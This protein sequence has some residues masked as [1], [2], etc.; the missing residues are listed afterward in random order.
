MNLAKE[1]VSWFGSMFDAEL[2]DKVLDELGAIMYGR[3]TFSIEPGKQV[4]VKR[5]NSK[6][7]F[8]C[9]EESV[10]FGLKGSFN[11]RFWSRWNEEK[12]RNAG[13]S[14]RNAGSKAIIEHVKS[15]ENK[16]EL[17]NLLTV[18]KKGQPISI[19]DKEY[20]TDTKEKLLV[21]QSIRDRLNQVA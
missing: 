14:V 5:S 10:S 18:V 17:S 20:A 3:R 8:S 7:V 6:L 21:A 11:L 4:K 1:I 15:L 16:K 12:R 9:N 13:T 19:N 2:S